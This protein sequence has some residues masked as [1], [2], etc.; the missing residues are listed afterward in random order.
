MEQ[1]EAISRSL[2]YG[3]R[4]KD[5]TNVK[6]GGLD[7]NESVWK[8]VCHLIIAGKN[9]LLSHDQHAVLR[10]MLDCLVHN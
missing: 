2:N 4:F 9:V 5:E 6:L 1:P 3:G 10:T 7:N 8:P